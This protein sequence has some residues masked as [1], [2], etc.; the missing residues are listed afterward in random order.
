M[1]RWLCKNTP[2]T[3]HNLEYLASMFHVKICLFGPTS[4]KY[5]QKLYFM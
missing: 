2:V 1:K 4:K 3:L 5:Q